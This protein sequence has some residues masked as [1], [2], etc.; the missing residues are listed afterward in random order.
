MYQG[1]R[2]DIIFDGF[3]VSKWIAPQITYI[4]FVHIY[5]Y[6]K[7]IYI[8]IYSLYCMFYK[9]S[10]P[11]FFG[12]KNGP[13][14][15]DFPAVRRRNRI[16]SISSVEAEPLLRSSGRVFDAGLCRVLKRL[17]IIKTRM[18][19]NGSQQ[20]STLQQIAIFSCR[21]FLCVDDM[22]YY[23]MYTVYTHYNILLYVTKV[24]NLDASTRV[25]P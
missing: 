13:N 15:Q 19:V 2:F 16:F 23:T 6:R 10:L 14:R 12:H 9:S 3:F 17:K 20:M 21:T 18:E 8:Y 4:Q 1:C 25:L 24:I 22:I 5:N 11:V 7:D